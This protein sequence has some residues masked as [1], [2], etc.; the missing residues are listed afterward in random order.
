MALFLPRRG[1][2]ERT[3][4]GEEGG[5]REGAGG[6]GGGGRGREARGEGGGGREG[7]A[8]GTPRRREKSVH[9]LHTVT[10]HM[11][12]MK[13]SKLKLLTVHF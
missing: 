8:D 2:K 5:G 9:R 6:A 4:R 13:L 3:G 11:C 7:R 10:E 12:E 1:K